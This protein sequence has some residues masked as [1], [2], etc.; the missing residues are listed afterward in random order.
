MKV[1]IHQ[2][3]YLPWLGYFHKMAMVDVFVLF[4]DTQHEKKC[5]ENR[6]GV[7]A[8]QGLQW[9]TVPVLKKGRFGQQIK[10]VEINNTAHWRRKHWRTI[11]Q[12][13]QR[14]PY[15][16]EYVDRFKT[17]Y[18]TEWTKLINLNLTYLELMKDILDIKTPLV[19]SS[20]IDNTELTGKDRIFNI[21]KELKATAFI[22]GMG[23]GTKRYIDPLDFK[24]VG[25]NLIYQNFKHPKYPQLWGEF[26]EGLSIIDALF[27]CGKDFISDRFF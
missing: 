16:K 17:I 9:L 20:Q 19:F 5:A 21:L 13:Y 12:A 1:A 25:I 18:S 27:N 3:N 8:S 11:E 26:E 14:A 10:D 23:R 22:A 7:K 6:V 4:D 2:P 24:E 15:F